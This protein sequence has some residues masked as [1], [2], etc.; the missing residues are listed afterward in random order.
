MDLK[1]TIAPPEQILKELISIDEF[2]NITQ[3]ENA[4][5]AQERGN[6]LSTYMARSGKLH[7]D[8]KHHL[9][10]VLKSDIMDVLRENAK[11]SNVSHKATNML[12]DCLCKDQRYLVDWAERIN[13]SCTHQLDWC[14]TVISKAKEEM[15]LAGMQRT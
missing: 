6:Q 8:A 10:A 15:R 11:K 12:I 1:H 14:R 7:S 13:K 2:L 4:E 3:S 9:N 5:E